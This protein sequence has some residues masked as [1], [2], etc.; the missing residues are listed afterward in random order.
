MANASEIASMVRMHIVDTQTPYRY[1]NIELAQRMTLAMNEIARRT[2]GHRG[3]VSID[4]TAG[5]KQYSID[6]DV[7]YK[8]DYVSY[9][10]QTGGGAQRLI[11]L[12]MED[13]IWKTNSGNGYAIWGDTINLAFEPSNSV[14]GGILIYAYTYP[15][16]V[17]ESDISTG[18]AVDMAL[19]FHQ[20]IILKTAT[21]ILLVDEEPAKARDLNALY[22]E[23]L[24]RI[25]ADEDDSTPF[26]TG[27][28]RSTYDPLTGGY[29]LPG[30]G[31]WF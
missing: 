23:E 25:K 22:E 13:S 30:E 8:I 4:T 1:S 19:K 20:A 27:R 18:A 12:Q 14:V 29:S 16:A 17:S 9:T 7:V 28:I 11:R 2:F 31:G 15:T 26:E 24:K 10:S 3:T 6:T 5:V 21:D